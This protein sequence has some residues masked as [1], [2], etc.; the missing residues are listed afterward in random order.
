MRQRQFNF[1]TAAVSFNALHRHLAAVSRANGFY[2]GK[3][4]AG[5]A[6][7]ARAR[8][9]HAEKTLKQ[10]RLVCRGYADAVVGHFEDGI[11]VRFRHAQ[12]HHAA[13]GRVFYGVVE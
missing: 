4:E 11:G 8:F 6:Q 3:A 7:I 10:M 13:G 12:V 5:A 1:K 9:V 2:D